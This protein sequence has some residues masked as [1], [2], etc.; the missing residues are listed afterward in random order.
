M[1]QHQQQHHHCQMSECRSSVV[2]TEHECG[3]RVCLACAME[4]ECLA[5]G[6]PLCA[7][8]TAQRLYECSVCQVACATC[9]KTSVTCGEC[10]TRICYDCYENGQYMC[11][12]CLHCGKIY[13]DGDDDECALKGGFYSNAGSCGFPTQLCE[14]CVNNKQQPPPPLS[15]SDNDDVDSDIIR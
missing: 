14:D 2:Y 13:C 15:G 9:D 12:E 11:A 6:T 7:Y 1:T 10:N 8:C 3:H 4:S 5:C